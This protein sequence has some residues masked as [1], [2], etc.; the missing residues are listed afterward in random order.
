MGISDIISLFDTQNLLSILNIESGFSCR[1][2]NLHRKK[3][4]VLFDK[5]FFLLKCHLIIIIYSDNAFFNRNWAGAC[6]DRWAG[7]GTAIG[8]VRWLWTLDSS[9]KAKTKR[10]GGGLPVASLMPKS[11]LP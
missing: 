11:V 7:I 3:I 9:S 2:S 1:V 4:L 6:W 10:I 5:Q 8:L